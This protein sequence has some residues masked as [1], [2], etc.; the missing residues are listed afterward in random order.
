MLISLDELVKK[1]NINI[2]G[3]LHV[4]AH[5]CEEMEYYEKY[6]NRSDILWIEAIPDKVNFC[7][8]KFSNLLIE[9]A[10]VS[11]KH[12]KIKFNIS[13]NG[14]SSS[15]LNLGLHK[16]YHPHITYVNSIECNTV[17]LS[18]ILDK[19]NNIP[20]NFINLDIQGAELKAIKGMGDYLNNIDYLYTE[21]N[22]GLVYDG[23]VLINEL[24]SYLS[25]YG[26]TRVET[27]M[28]PYEWGDAFYIKIK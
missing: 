4:G 18:E 2:K 3:V 22:T 9:N 13:N 5:E 28:T 21:I 26:F 16:K 19:Y 8:K 10:V 11:D 1:Y 17:L 27:F 25:R 6:V 12:E 24:D 14:A 15:M 23:C 20:F 7:K